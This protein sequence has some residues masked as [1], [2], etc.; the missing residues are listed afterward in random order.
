MSSFGDWAALSDTVDVATA[1]VLKREISDGIIAPGYDPDAL[2]VLRRKKK[3]T[4]PIIQIDSNYEPPEMETREVFGLSLEQKR[5][6]VVIDTGVLNNVAT[7]NSTL[8]PSVRRDLL[9]ATITLKYTQSNS[10]C[11]ALDGQIIGAGAGQQSRIHCTRLAAEKAEKWFLR[12]HPGVTGLRFRKKVKRQ[13]KI[14]AVQ[15]Y[16]MHGEMTRHERKKWEALFQEKPGFLGKAQ[17]SEWLKKLTAVSM[18]SDA[19]IPFRD[20]VDRAARAG[21]KYILQT[22]GSIRDEEVIE[23]ADE[24]GMVMILSGLRLFHH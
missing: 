24:Y 1:L 9:L 3:G 18:S 6:N 17:K 8:P 23:A 13:Q 21:V 5:N 14:N 19:F 10:V 20:N 16:L 2:E 4:Y 7:R 15:G 22:G 12:Q 11:F